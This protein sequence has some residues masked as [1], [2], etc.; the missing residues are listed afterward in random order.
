MTD[1][2]QTFDSLLRDALA[3]RAEGV[4]CSSDLDEVFDKVRTAASMFD[5]VIAE[6]ETKVAE[7]E[8]TARNTK[9]PETGCD[10]ES[11]SEALRW[12]LD[13]LRK[14]GATCFPFERLRAAYRWMTWHFG[15]ELERGL[16]GPYEQRK[17][18]WWRE[19]MKKVGET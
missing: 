10:A 1:K 13:V 12:A 7:C 2:I 8:N 4:D 14:A 6:I 17:R 11:W 9:D 3:M 16:I 15:K 5:A 18:Y 19:A